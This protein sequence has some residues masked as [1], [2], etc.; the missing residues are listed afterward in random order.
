MRRPNVMPPA[1][2]TLQ[3]ALQN[4]PSLAQLQAVARQSAQWWQWVQPTLP[5]GI[6]AQ[7]TPAGVSEDG[8]WCLLVANAATAAKL[9]QFQPAMQAQLRSKGA[10]VQSIRIKLRGAH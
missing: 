7:V 2:L 3:A 9:R 8:Q 1:P 4:A 10:P 5:A 6:V